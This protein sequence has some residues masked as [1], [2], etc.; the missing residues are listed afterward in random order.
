MMLPTEMKRCCRV[1]GTAMTT[2]LWKMGKEN[3]WI[4]SST[5]ILRRGFTTTNNLEHYPLYRYVQK[6]DMGLRGA[7]MFPL[8]FEDV[9]DMAE[10]ASESVYWMAAN[11]LIT[12]KR[13]QTDAQGDL[14]PGPGNCAHLQSS[15]IQAAGSCVL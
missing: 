2:R 3:H 12:K 13:R 5:Q 15:H 9:A 1:L 10:Y 8:P 6:F 4:F 14:E 11:D 7:W